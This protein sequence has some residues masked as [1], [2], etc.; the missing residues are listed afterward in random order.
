MKSKKDCG[1]QRVTPPASQT[2]ATLSQEFSF[3][4][5]M[6]SFVISYVFFT[7]I[8]DISGRTKC[9]S[10]YLYVYRNASSI[11]NREWEAEENVERMAREAREQEWDW[12][13]TGKAVKIQLSRGVS[14]MPSQFRG[15]NERVRCSQQRRQA[16]SGGKFT[17]IQ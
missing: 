3:P 10:I 1:P 17:K 5:A 6:L 7:K 8:C 12:Q 4:L 9:L 11:I 14:P 13:T 2:P 16:K 15:S